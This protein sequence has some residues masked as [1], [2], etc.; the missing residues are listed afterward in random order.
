MKGAAS[1]R[2]CNF[3]GRINKGWL[4][5]GPRYSITDV[6]LRLRSRGTQRNSNENPRLE[7]QHCT[8]V[9][10]RPLVLDAGIGAADRH[11]RYQEQFSTYRPLLTII[12]CN[13]LYELTQ[14]AYAQ[15]SSCR[16][17][18]SE[19]SLPCEYNCTCAC[20]CHKERDTHGWGGSDYY[21]RAALQFANIERG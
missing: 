21:T 1:E 15:N 17:L 14:P 11:D 9:I 5:E 8:N 10:T 4:R 16:V 12:P 2:A 18:L 19:S 3:A 13:I 6:H 7:T 20:V